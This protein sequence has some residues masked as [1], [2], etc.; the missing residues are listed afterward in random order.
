MT[1]NKYQ[2]ETASGM[3]F[4]NGQVW[5]DERYVCQHCREQREAE[6]KYYRF[7]SEQYS[8]NI[9]AGRYCYECW[10]LSGYRDVDDPWAKFDPADAGESMEPLD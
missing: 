9:Y 1:L 10:L 6:G 4:S 7:A 5:F 2:R 3:E 8:F